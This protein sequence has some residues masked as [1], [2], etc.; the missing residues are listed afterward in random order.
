MSRV[1]DKRLFG[2]PREKY[3]VTYI[4]QRI[5]KNKNFLGFISGQTGSGK[6]WSCLSI[7]EG[8]DPKF[9]IDRVVFSGLELMQLINSDKLKKGSAIMFDE[10]SIDMDNRNWNST[11]NKMINHLMQTFRYRGFIMLMNS[12]F[13]D[14]VDAKTRKLFHADIGIQ[15]INYD[16]EEAVLMPRIIQ[17]NSRNQKFYYKRL[18]VSTPEF[19]TVPIDTWTVSKPSEELRLAYEAKKNHY[20]CL[21]NEK[22]E[23]ELRLVANPENKIDRRKKVVDMDCFEKDVRARLSNS[24]L[25]AKYDIGTEKCRV[26][27]HKLGSKSVER[28][29]PEKF[30]EFRMPEKT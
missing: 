16:K 21:L 8:I 24:A 12:P 22:I 13:M 4:K 27:K 28:F 11:T 20:S 23:K 17:F 10:M 14:F 30:S 15:G 26:L 3:W 5:R 18:K 1:V 7:C 6:S 2:K 29:R 19:G 25:C 9:G